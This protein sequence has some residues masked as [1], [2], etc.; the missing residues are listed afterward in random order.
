M[1][2]LTLTTALT[3]VLGILIDG[4]GDGLL[5]GD[6]R[7]ADVGL[8]L[9]LAEQ[10]VDDD[11][12]M[13]LAH[14]GDDGLTGL[15]VSVG[16]E[17]RV[18]LGQLHQ[19]NAHLLLT[20]L[21]LG[22]DGDA[23][24]GLGELHG[25]EDDRSLFIAERITGGGVL[26]ADDGADIAGVAALNV[27]A[28][29]GVHLQDAADALSLMLG[30][31]EDRGTGIEDT[32]VNTNEGQTA[33]ER[34]GRDLE[35]EA[36]EGSVVVRVTDVF[37][38]GVGV[39]TIDRG[40][41]HG[42]RH[43]VDDRVQQ[44]LNALVLVRG[45][46]GDRN[47]LVV[48]GGLTDGLADE[49]LR[50]GL[51]FER[52]LHDLVVQ[53]GAG[54]DQLGA[55]LLSQLKHIRRDLFNAHILA[56]LVIVDVSVHLHQVDDALEGIFRADRQLDGDSVALETVVDHVQHVVEVRAHDIHLV[57]V[58]HAGNLV[59]IGLAPHSL[60]LGLDAALGAEN[61]HAAVQNAQ[62]TLDLNGEVDVA[63]GIDDVET[64]LGELVLAALPV[65][66]GSGGGDGDTTLLLLRHPVHRGGTVVGLAD[67]VV[68]AGIVEDTLGGGRLAGV[69]MGHNADI[70]GIF[71][72][73]FSCHISVS[74][75]LPAEVGECLVGFGHLVGVFA[76]LHGAAAVVG[77]IHD[78]A[79]Q[80]L[81]HGALTAGTG[82]GRQPAQT[83]GL[84]TGGTDLHRDLIGGATDAA[85]LGFQAGHDILH[86]LVENIEGLVAGLVL[87]H[88]KGAVNDLLSNTLLAVEHDAVDKLGH[89]N[90][91][92]HRIGQ[93]FSLG[94]ITS[95]GHF[96]SLLLI[97]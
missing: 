96:A 48:D 41:I 38:T 85:G 33:N 1:T 62:G 92:V 61:G 25:L 19:R 12:Q 45:T 20:G 53:V 9:V 50:N 90:A 16:L 42:G 4:L 79:G 21:G 29:V 55:I 91:V 64:G 11:L 17:G 46:A 24:N 56:E 5:I 75:P 59:V 22:L 80:T 40:D 66:G 32:G 60:G 57:D 43:K 26:E 97:I 68:D 54:I 89:Q 8:D 47:H 70:S 39:H 51:L 94:N 84:T 83:E 2:V 82:I 15:F 78:L 49:V 52:Q 18:L 37:L 58:D 71:Q 87:D 34:V 31:V 73:D 6:L 95:S 72:R 74:P 67:L 3:G 28:V 86:G 76:L 81:G 14:T 10:T 13:E 7:C 36:G 88:I 30:G 27:L 93:N 44:L 35:R 23:D 69:D 77:S 63:R 65:A